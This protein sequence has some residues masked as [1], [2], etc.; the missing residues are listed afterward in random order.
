MPTVLAFAWNHAVFTAT[1]AIEAS[2]LTR[3]TVIGLC[4]DLLKRG[5]LTEL[6]DSRAAGAYQ[7]G[8]P[9]RRY[10]FAAS[11]A[12]VVGVDAGAHSVT[13]VV[14]DLRGTHLGGATASR[15]HTDRPTRATR[16]AAIDQSITKALAD[17]AVQPEQVLCVVVGVPAPTNADGASPTVGEGFW[18]AM[19]PGI[20]SHLRARGWH[21]LVENDAN[22]AAIAE[23]AI[24]AATGMD[25]YVTVLCDERM[26]AG[27]VVDGALMRGSRGGVGELHILDFVEQVGDTDGVGV[28][29]KR[30][31]HEALASGVATPGS[32]LAG[33]P[34][35]D[36][37]AEKILAAMDTDAVAA[38]IGERLAGRLAW[39]SAL[40]GSLFDADRIVFAGAVA[41]SLTPVLALSA[42]VLPTLMPS[43]VPSLVAS[44]L[45]REVVAIGAVHHAVTWAKAN[46]RA[47]LADPASMHD[48]SQT[49]PA[50]R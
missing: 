20:G 6:P 27:C 10:A 40:L 13:V 33:L 50:S 17:A 28:L 23:G 15:R 5:W 29:A 2:G 21:T 19:N 35:E 36:L 34:P 44:T 4:D 24:G 18:Q 7:K 22:L 3:S 38:G 46:V 26:G 32:V 43:Q 30:W 11:R 45:G 14:A 42:E 8:R 37:S 16:L 41:P 48:A 12:V 25:S 39:V 49:A 1:D 31:A 9:A 47:L